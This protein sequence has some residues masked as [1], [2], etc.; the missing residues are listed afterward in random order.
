[1][2]SIEVGD[3][4]RYSVRFLRSIGAYTGVL[5]FAQGIVVEMLPLSRETTLARIQWDRSDIPDKVNTAN[6]VQ[7]GQTELD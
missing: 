7:V 6:L 1:M 4:V 3:R 2:K 5:P